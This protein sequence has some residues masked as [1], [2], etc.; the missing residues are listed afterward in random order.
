MEILYKT[1]SNQQ[2]YT[3]IKKYY[4]KNL[5]VYVRNNKSYEFL[6]MWYGAGG[7]GTAAAVFR[8]IIK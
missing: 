7:A 2:I 8:F 6:C 1:F 5:V 3:G 4:S